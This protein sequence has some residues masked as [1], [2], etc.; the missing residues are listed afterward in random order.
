MAHSFRKH[1]SSS[2]MTVQIITNAE[3]LHEL[4]EKQDKY[5]A[6]LEKIKNIQIQ[7]YLLTS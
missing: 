2:Y 6:N 3:R 5:E 4:Q 1:Q 7:N